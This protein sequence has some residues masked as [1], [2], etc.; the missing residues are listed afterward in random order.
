VSVGDGVGVFD[1]S[2][3]RVWE[4]AIDRHVQIGKLL[5]VSAV[6]T[7][8][9][10]FCEKVAGKFPLNTEAPLLSHRIGHIR[11]GGPEMCGL[12]IQIRRVEKVSRKS[13]P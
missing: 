2:K 7:H 4:N 3:V 6:S 12:E 8:I 9:V 1:I 13:V 11:I 10:Q 5:Q